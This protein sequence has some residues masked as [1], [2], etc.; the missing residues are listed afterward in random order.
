MMNDDLETSIDRRPLYR[1][2]VLQGTAAASSHRGTCSCSAGVD[3]P[4]PSSHLTINAGDFILT[5]D[6]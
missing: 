2:P 4:S 1:P 5:I 6:N 3:A